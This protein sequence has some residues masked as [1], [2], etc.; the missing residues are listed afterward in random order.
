M[1]NLNDLIWYEKY[2][3]TK[4]K[5]LIL[6][7]KYYK[8]FSS[9]LKKKEIPHLL[10]HGPA[11]SGKTTLARILINK[12][13]GRSL[14]LNSSSSDRGIDTV[15]SRV[16]Q[17]AK[18]TKTSKKLNIIFMDE[19]DGMTP[20]AQE[21]LKNTIE[22][23]H[24]NCR[25]IFTAN[26]IEQ[27]TDPII[28]RCQIYHF[29]TVPLKTL[30]KQLYKILDSEEVKYKRIVVKEISKL[31]YPDV[32]AIMNSLQACSIGGKLNKNVIM[33]N[34]DFKHFSHLLKT[35]KIFAIRNMLNNSTSYLPIYKYLF[36]KW[37]IKH[38]PDEQISEALIT[39]AEYL[40]RDNKAIDKEINLTACLLELMVMMEAEISYD[41]PF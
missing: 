14:I 36:N 24:K 1:S 16:Q 2:R 3:P 13:A 26:K 32:R 4:L 7:E 15:K 25:F 6:Q 40:Y 8:V 31:L 23:F 18:A 30:N 28:S 20:P 11:G 22:A 33:Q 19:A 27:I 29:N 17:F 9:F 12:C 34:I 21:A 38:I 37:I 39:T 41:E 35:G 10:F 5:E